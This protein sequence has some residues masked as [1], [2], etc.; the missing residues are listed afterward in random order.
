MTTRIWKDKN[1]IIKT[2]IDLDYRTIGYGSEYTG[3]WTSAKTELLFK[4]IECGNAL[5][6]ENG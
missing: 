2:N 4:C 1:G 6:I 3:T 5:G